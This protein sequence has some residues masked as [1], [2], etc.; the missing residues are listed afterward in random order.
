MWQL[1]YRRDSMPSAV[2]GGLVICT[3]GGIAAGI[4]DGG[5]RLRRQRSQEERGRDWGQDRGRFCVVPRNWRRWAGLRCRQRAFGREDRPKDLVSLRPPLRVRRLCDLG[6]HA[7]CECA[8][9]LAA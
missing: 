5:V 4:M 1:Q 6:G 2:K 3:P 9:V 8:C 7:G